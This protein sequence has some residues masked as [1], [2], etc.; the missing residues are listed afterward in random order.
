LLKLVAP[1]PNST[2]DNVA[3]GK[4]LKSITGKI[5][6]GRQLLRDVSD[7]QRPKWVLAKV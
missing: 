6:N 5:V 7:K 3:L 2:I 4:W 1:G